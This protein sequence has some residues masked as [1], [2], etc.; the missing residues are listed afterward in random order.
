MEKAPGAKCDE[1]PLKEMKHVPGS[2]PNSAALAVVG[3]A[4]GA[5]EIATGVPFSGVSG[6]L[7]NN[8]LKYHGIKR[9]ETYVTNVVLCRPPDNRTPTTKEIGACHNR[10]IQE[11]RGTG[12]KSVLAL[13]ATAAQSLLASRT[14]ISKLR[15]EPDL[16]SPYLGSGV[17]VIPTF[18]PA[19][20][21]RTP[22]YFPSILKD[23]AKINA[24]QVVWEHTKYQVVDNEVKARDLLSKQVE[25]AAGNGGIITFDAEL[26]IEAIKGAVD[27][28]NPVWL[29]AGISSRP[30][31][32]VVYTPEVLTPNFWA[33]LNDTFLDNRLRW[34]YQNG[35]FD[36]QPLWGS[37]VTNARVDEDTMLMHYSTDERKGTHDLEQ[38]AVEILGAPAYKTDTRRFL[39]RTGASLRYLPPDILHQYNAAD[40]DVTHRLVD[41]LQSEMKSD[42]VERPYYELLIPGSDVLGRAEYLG[43]KVDRDR[44]DEL[45]DELWEELI[46]KRK[47]LEQWVANPNSPK[48]IKAMLDDVY[49]I[50]TESTDKEHLQA[51][52]EK[53]GGEIGEF[54][55]KLLDYRQQAKLRS[56]YVVG[57]AK[58]LVRSRVHTTFLLHGTDT[59]RLSSRNPNLQNIPSGSKIRDLYV[60]GPENV[61]LSAD[62]SQIEFR[63]AAILS[64]DEWL[65]DQFR[66]NRSFHTEV[67]HRFFGEDYT[68]LQYLRAKAVNFGILY[69][70][71]AKS[72]A[73][74]HKFPVAEG[75]RMIREFYQQMPKVK[76]YQDDIHRQIRH[77]GYLESYFGR[78]R[79]FWLVTRE[80]WHMV[81]KEGVA[82][83]TQSA[84]SDLNLQSA[85]RLEPLLRGKA[86]VLIPVHDS[87]VFECRRQYLEEVAYTVREV[88]EDTPVRDICPTPIEIKVGLKWGSHRGRCPDRVCYHL[89]EYKGGPYVAAA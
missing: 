55:S 38:L 21:L 67:A 73:D 41:P 3:E 61:L 65:L 7:L 83:P 10:L 31:A 12:A 75:Y 23:V 82:F 60:A 79:R 45:A 78:K 46:P 70:R 22:D 74:E 26:D 59:G 64:G 50:D 27:L 11:L 32:A 85:I 29:C 6:Q 88:M 17:H 5:G 36:L 37:G 80:N 84:A 52:K 87:L 43:T 30:G 14:A 81:S 89:K 24:V 8:I 49:D 19:A 42:G 25:Q 35:K 4:P 28:K 9:E 62:Y 77:N 72:L 71:G 2:G 40:A 57:L 44:L 58:R 18:H 68:E 1:C 69:L 86:A 20:A 34:T 63:L 47:E 39:P 54:V 33:Q 53:H 76:E 66:Q 48:Q 15:T 51:I 16:A 13:G 56:T